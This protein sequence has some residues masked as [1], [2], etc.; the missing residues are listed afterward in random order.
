MTLQTI[1]KT[2]D[3]QIATA[4]RIALGLLFVMTGVMK[5]AVP[6]LGA[7]FAG[8]LAA[9]N[10]PF[11]EIQRWVVPFIEVGVGGA[12]LAGYYTR[13]ATLL[14]LNIMVVA[15]YVHMMVDDPALASRFSALDLSAETGSLR[16]FD[17]PLVFYR[18][19][20]QS[21]PNSTPELTPGS[22]SNCQ[23]GAKK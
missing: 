15:I 13:L 8:Q 4:V 21:L 17:E 19:Q 12:L 14:V 20:C 16:G 9:G 2:K 18:L 23:I 7:A 22:A 1:R 10:I 5:L 6:A 11:A 3:D